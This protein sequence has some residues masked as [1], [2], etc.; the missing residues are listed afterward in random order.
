M[1][2]SFLAIDPDWLNG[3]WPGSKGSGSSVYKFLD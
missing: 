1:G 3:R 2:L